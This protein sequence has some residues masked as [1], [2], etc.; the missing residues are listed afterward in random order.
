ML[1]VML[2]FFIAKLENILFCKKN[3][4]YFFTTWTVVSP[5]VVTEISL[6]QHQPGNTKGGSITAPLTS[7][8]TGLESAV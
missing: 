6:R 5:A 2:P 1:S 7:C 4:I 3:I 8:L